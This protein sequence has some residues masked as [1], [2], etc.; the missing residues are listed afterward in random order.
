MLL[1]S[2]APGCG[3]SLP[4]TAD[5]A[6]A[7]TALETALAA[8]QNGGTIESLQALTPPIYFNESIWMRGNRLVGYEFKSEER[9]GVSWRCDV[10]LNLESRDNKQRQRTATY[11]IDI[12][13]AI[14]IT[15]DS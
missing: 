7:R 12:A 13:E 4:P 10:L 8:W 5:P 6:Q 1:L 3:Q 9:N 15:Q 11:F 2:I 14:V